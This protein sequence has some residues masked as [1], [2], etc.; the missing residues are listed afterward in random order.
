MEKTSSRCLSDSASHGEAAKK[1]IHEK[2]S[3]TATTLKQDRVSGV[4]K[5]SSFDTKGFEY[6]RD[7]SSKLPTLGSFGG[8]EEC[9]IV[10]ENTKVDE[11]GS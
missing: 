6:Q 10:Y 7:V 8:I 2:A 9:W 3:G 5:E 11:S 1:K 4:E